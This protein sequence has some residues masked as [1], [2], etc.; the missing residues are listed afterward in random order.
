MQTGNSPGLF[1]CASVSNKAIDLYKLMIREIQ[2]IFSN[3]EIASFFWIIV[4]VIVMSFKKTFRNSMGQVVIAFLNKKILSIIFVTFLYFACIVFLLSLVQLWDKSMIKD[5]LYWFLMTALVI[6]FNLTKA[7][8]NA[9][10]FRSI[11]LD[12]FKF[13]LLLEFIVN[14]H[15]F[16]LISEIIFIAVIVF[17]SLLLSIAG[18][19]SKY[20]VAEKGITIVFSFIGLTLLILSIKDIVNSIHE[21][22]NFEA[23]KSFLLPMELSIT[24]VPF[25]YLTAVLIDYEVLFKRYTIFLENKNLLRYARRRTIAKYGIRLQQIKSLTPLIMREFYA[26]ITKEEIREILK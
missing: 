2:I 14:I 26:G 9:D 20:N 25:A 24:F 22:A 5:S 1:L 23:L 4:A 7:N 16:S 12:N 17:L 13:T 21:Y 19:D 15:N 18:T 10:Y 3:R 8:E 6:H 11:I